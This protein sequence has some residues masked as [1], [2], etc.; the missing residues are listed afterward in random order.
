MAK[1]VVVV[2]AASQG[3]RWQARVRGGSEHSREV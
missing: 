2:N 3:A 1:V